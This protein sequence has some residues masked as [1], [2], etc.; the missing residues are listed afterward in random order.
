MSIYESLGI[1][2][3]INA[4]ATLTRLG[5]SL[6]PPEVLRAMSEA[7]EHFVDLDDL[8]RRVGER[9][10]AVTR[11]EAAYVSSGAAAG[12]VLAAASCITGADEDLIHRFPH[13]GGLKDEVIVHRSHPIILC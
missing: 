3:V 11:N 4:R 13:L 12:L 8:Q 5:G 7:A 9:I 2:P 6:M 1:R 10:A